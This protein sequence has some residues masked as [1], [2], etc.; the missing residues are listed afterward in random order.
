M[1]R[2]TLV[3]LD[4]TVVFP[5]MPVTLSLDIGDDKHVFLIPRQ[6]GQ[7]A[8][9]GVVAEVKER[10]QL[11]GRGVAVS[12]IGLHRGV[13][14]AAQNDDRD[15]RLRVEVE[16]RPDVI[17]PPALTHE[18]ERKY[19][20]VVEEILELRGDDGR[21]SAFVK[22]ITNTGSTGGHSRVLSGFNFPQKIE[23]LET[24]DVVERLKLALG[25]SRSG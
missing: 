17:P 15:G 24:L 12:L 21:L 8:K 20:A 25:S 11:P 16:P 14:G 3:S 23:L 2:L 22:S 18:L 5:G 19:R 9:A 4:E 10:I 13:P 6:A 7:Y 1:T